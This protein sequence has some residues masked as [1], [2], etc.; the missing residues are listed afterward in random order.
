M[1]NDNNR[2]HAFTLV[3][4]L[5]VIGIIA[6][7][8]SVL[9]PVLS[10]ARAAA[11]KVGCAS[12]LRSLAQSQIMYAQT[13]KRFPPS[14]NNTAVPNNLDA[15]YWKAIIAE[16]MKVPVR[17]SGSG[18][19]NAISGL[20][21]TGTFLCPAYAGRTDM[22][23]ALMRGYAMN[24]NFARWWDRENPVTPNKGGLSAPD[25]ARQKDP[26]RFRRTMVLMTDGLFNDSGGDLISPTAVNPMTSST[27]LVDMIRHGG[28]YSRPPSGTLGSGP[29]VV[30]RGGIN[31]AFTDGRVEFVPINGA[32]TPNA[33][34][35]P[36]EP[37]LRTGVNFSNTGLDDRLWDMRLQ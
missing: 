3:E 34:N 13:W 29:V 33:A 19:P 1:T 12:N 6:V 5:V 7:L 2:R 8:I 35:A 22:Q 9:L 4:L 11:T 23:T 26:L 37:P 27:G 25:D 28:A 30:V 31:I 21:S 10:K 17:Y 20:G 18:A 14:W 16:S 36:G 15:Q 24:T 32:G